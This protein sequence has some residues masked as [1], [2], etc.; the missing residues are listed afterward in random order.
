VIV[1]PFAS[2]NELTFTT[3]VASGRGDIKTVHDSNAQSLRQNT[4]TDA[5]R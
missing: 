5:R 2:E 3:S 1:S 4:K